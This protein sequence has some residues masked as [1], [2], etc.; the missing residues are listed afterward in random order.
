MTKRILLIS[1]VLIGCLN[2]AVG[3]MGYFGLIKN[4]YL[5]FSLMTAL[6]VCIFVVAGIY[7]YKF[8]SFDRL[9]MVAMVAAAASA[10]AIIVAN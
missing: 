3:F 6:L 9:M 2:L 8:R 7:V 10:F 5:L 1:L 4:G